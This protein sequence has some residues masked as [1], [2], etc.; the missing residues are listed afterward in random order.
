MGIRF[1]KYAALP[2]LGIL[3][4]FALTTLHIFSF[5]SHQA[6]AERDCAVVFGAAVWP[7]YYGP[8]P[9]DALTDRTLASA[10]LYKKGLVDCIILSGA[11][12]IYGAHEVDIMTDLLLDAQVPIDIIKLDRYGLDTRSTIENLDKGKSYILISN[13][14]HLARI[15]FFA[16]YLGLEFDTHSAEYR[17]GGRYTREHHFVAREVVAFWY[18]F[19]GTLF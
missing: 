9:S 4:I 13:D 7:G 8:V 6:E 11:D 19:F 12:S 14:F 15:D 16:Q 10:E 3:A 17:S 18:Y 2:V 1:L 5:Y